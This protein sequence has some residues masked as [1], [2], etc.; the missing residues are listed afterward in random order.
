[1]AGL[2]I[3]LPTLRRHPRG[4]QRTAWGRCGS[5]LLHRSGLAPPA[6]CR[7][8]PAHQNPSSWA[9]RMNERVRVSAG[10]YTR[11]PVVV[12]GGIFHALEFASA[13]GPLSIGE[14]S[15]RTRVN[16]ETIRYHE[17]ITMLPTVAEDCQ[18]GWASPHQAVAEPDRQDWAFYRVCPP[19]GRAGIRFPRTA[20]P[21]GRRIRVTKFFA[22][23]RL[24]PLWLAR[25]RPPARGRSPLR[26]GHDAD[27]CVLVF[28]RV[29]RLR[30]P[31]FCSYRTV[32]CPPIQ[33]ARA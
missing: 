20:H 19:D 21:L 28:L 32:S 31:V 14:L 10:P 23:A 2:C 15:R 27:R 26:Y 6:P 7:F 8:V 16:I 1:M 25:T 13:A 29:L 12:R 18:C 11:R 5:L 33:Q 30:H 24:H 22:A 4:C 17:R 9:R 3:P